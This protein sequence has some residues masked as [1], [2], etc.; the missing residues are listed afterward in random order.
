M[1][2]KP[3]F[4]KVPPVLGAAP[5]PAPPP[6]EDGTNGGVP[7]HRRAG[8]EDVPARS[9]DGRQDRPQ[10]TPGAATSTCT[11]R[12][13]ERR[14]TAGRAAREHRDRTDPKD[15]AQPAATTL[16]ATDPALLHLRIRAGDEHVH[17]Q[18]CHARGHDILDGGE[19]RGLEG[20][21]DG[22]PHRRRLGHEGVKDTASLLLERL[23]DAL[24]LVRDEFTRGRRTLDLR[25]VDLCGGGLLERVLLVL[26]QFLDLTG[27]LA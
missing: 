2:A 10:T 18:R 9:E 7:P 14:R 1:P 16:A 5:M 27:D 17:Q 25:H 12:W 23:E 19:Q 26:A 13:Q 22:R 24:V 21:P 8:E 3:A 4:E 11:A 15:A 20:V 6:D